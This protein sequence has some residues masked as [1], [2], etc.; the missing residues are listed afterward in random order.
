MPENRRLRGLATTNPRAREKGKRA[1]QSAQ[2]FAMGTAHRASKAKSRGALALEAGMDAY[3]SK[4]PIEALGCCFEAIR[5]SRGVPH[6]MFARKANVGR[7]GPI[8]EEGPRALPRENFFNSEGA[9][10]ADALGRG[11]T[12]FFGRNWLGK[13]SFVSES[14]VPDLAGTRIRDFLPS[15]TGKKRLRNQLERAAHSF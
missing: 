5:E 11:N 1:P 2:S 4:A 7:E 12:R 13:A 9:V 14:P 6:G 15:T 10:W 8:P 3:V